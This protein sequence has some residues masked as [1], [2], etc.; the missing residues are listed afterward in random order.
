MQFSKNHDQICEGI[1]GY[2]QKNEKGNVNKNMSVN[3]NANKNISEKILHRILK[4]LSIYTT[5]FIKYK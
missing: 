3:W 5:N 1:S 4:K 2:V